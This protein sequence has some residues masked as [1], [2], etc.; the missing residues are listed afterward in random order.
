VLALSFSTSSTLAHH[1]AR[2]VAWT[3]AGKEMAETS[4]KTVTLPAVIDLDSLDKVRDQLLE[5]VE[6][7]PVHVV[8]GAVERVATNG[9]FMLL[10]AAETARHNG[11]RLVLDRPSPQLAGAIG[12]LGLS[13]RFAEFVTG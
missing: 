9:L 1:T 13:E 2:Q 6:T 3:G 10:S 8:A 7:G 5:A 12:R 11:F 4:G